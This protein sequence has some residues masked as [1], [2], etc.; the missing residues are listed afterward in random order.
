MNFPILYLGEQIMKPNLTNTNSDAG[1]NIRSEQTNFSLTITEI[2]KIFPSERI[3]SDA[4]QIYGNCTTGALRAIPAALLIENKDEIPKVLE[5]CQRNGVPVYPISTGKNWGYGTA[6]PV[7]N[8]CILLDLSRLNKIV[9]LDPELATVRI[10]PGVTQGQLF[11]FLKTHNLDFLVPATGAG[12]HASLMGNLLE[13]GY[14]ITPH[15]DHFAALLALEVVLPTGEIYSS[16]LEDAGCPELNRNF[17]WGLGPY[18]DGLFAQSNFGIVTE[19]TIALMKKPEAIEAFVFTLN[20]NSDLTLA[21]EA[22]REISQSLPGI[23]GGMNIMNSRRMLAMQSKYPRDKVDAGEIL[24]ADQILSLRKEHSIEVWTGVGGI[25][26]TQEVVRAAKK[27]IR[28]K[29]NKFVKEVRFVN[30]SKLDLLKKTA[31]WCPAFLGGRELR[32]LAQ[33]VAQLLDVVSG[34]PTEAALP[35][36]YWKLEKSYQPGQN[37]N[38]A[39]DGC[40]LMWYSP[41]VVNRPDNVKDYVEFV[42]ETCTEFGMEPLITL[43][44]I[45]ERCFDSTVPLLFD[46]NDAEEAQRAK[47]CLQALLRRGQTKGYFPYR[48]GVEQMAE[49]TGNVQ[50]V[51]WNTVSRI[52]R[53]LDPKMILSPGR[54]SPSNA[55]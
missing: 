2:G 30:S 1:N 33:R 45:S 37:I 14:G 18:L 19:C 46:K 38:I 53:A 22:L 55:E 51:S 8:G 17:N 52:K 48:L 23:L 50:S 43:T 29:L 49:V 6:N 47:A 15:T 32:L 13:R 20:Q 3:I 9:D 11:E 10:Q 34:V 39:Q 35:L 31:K 27:H 40:G 4:N 16:T 21:T 12:P 25:Y 28:R 36:V 7:E 44:T 24:N 26:G 54:Y 42:E 5:I 41:L